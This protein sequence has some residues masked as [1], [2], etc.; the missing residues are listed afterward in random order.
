M[1]N[2]RVY[3]LAF[4]FTARDGRK[5]QATARTSDPSRLEDEREEPLLFDPEKPQDAVLLDEAP[6]RPSFDETGTMTGRPL[7]A[8]LAMIIPA[9]VIAANTLVLLAKLG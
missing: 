6:S 9:V 8:L 3:E 5:Y 2:R 1:N 7:A 4:E